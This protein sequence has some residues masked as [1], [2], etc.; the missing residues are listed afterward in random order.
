MYIDDKRSWFL[1]ADQH[2]R[3]C[4]GGVGVGSVV[5]VLLNLESHELTF[6]VNDEQQGP[7]AF[8]DLKGVFYPAFSLNRNVSITV[9]TGIDPPISSGVNSA[10]ESESSDGENKTNK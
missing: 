3:R 6:F 4:E 8:T 10:V 9:T 1:H 2:D 5:G 7:I